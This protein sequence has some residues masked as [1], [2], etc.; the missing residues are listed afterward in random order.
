MAD[1][2]I[3]RGDQVDVPNVGCPGSAAFGTTVR[4]Y[5]QQAAEIEDN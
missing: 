1:V 3:L 2:H 5:D 4:E